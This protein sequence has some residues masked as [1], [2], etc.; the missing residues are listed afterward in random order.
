MVLNTGLMKNREIRTS[1]HYKDE[2]EAYK[3]V[4]I[5]RK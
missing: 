4:E 3:M 5:E 2:V 1:R